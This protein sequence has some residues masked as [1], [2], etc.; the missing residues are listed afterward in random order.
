MLYGTTFIDG[1]YRPV[2]AKQG[3][4]WTQVVFNDGGS[5]RVKRTKERLQFKPIPNYTI[6]K[7]ANRMLRSRNGLGIK[8]QVSKTARA[9]LKEA[10]EKHHA[11]KVR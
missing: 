10:K 9:I 2:I 3:R 1:G 4:I 6:T 8:K 11:S 7:L 5:V